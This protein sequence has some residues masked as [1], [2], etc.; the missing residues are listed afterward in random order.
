MRLQLKIPVI[1]LSVHSSEPWPI[2]C[3]DYNNARIKKVNTE[4][5]GY[6]KFTVKLS[7]K[8]NVNFF[9]TAPISM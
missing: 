6:S 1:I 8:K 4:Q 7:C 5:D 3:H 9:W 2:F